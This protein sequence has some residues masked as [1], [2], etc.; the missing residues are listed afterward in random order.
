MGMAL[1]PSRDTTEAGGEPR[2]IGVDSEEADD[3]FA[4]LSAATARELVAALS[5]SP[6]PPGE[7]ADRVDTSLQ[8]AQY[9]LE[10]LEAADAVE[11][12]DTA[13]S[14]KGREMDVYAPANEPL[15][16]CAGDER[17]TE[18][19]K[20]A[21]TSLF[22]RL[23]VLAAVSALIQQTFGTGMIT[24]LDGSQTTTVD[25]TAPSVSYLPD[26]TGTTE[27]ASRAGAEASTAV[28]AATTI[29]PGLAFFAG[30]AVVLLSLAVLWQYRR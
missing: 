26:R 27:V 22:G 15:V 10:K 1:L 3:M 23:A 9:H 2:V 8:N 24:L 5:N 17:E 13:Y 14:E 28:D 11:V 7:L 6:A 20:H 19:L 16:I 4:A 25:S 21:V 30:G 18:G 12:V 29:P